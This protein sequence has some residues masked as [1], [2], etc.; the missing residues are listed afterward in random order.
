MTHPPLPLH[1]HPILSPQK[2]KP[3]KRQNHGKVEKLENFPSKTIKTEQQQ[4]QQQEM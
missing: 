1:P 2:K 3:K 4:Q